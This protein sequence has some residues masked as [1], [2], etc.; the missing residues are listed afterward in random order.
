MVQGKY[1][2]VVAVLGLMLILGAPSVWADAHRQ[3]EL[4]PPMAVSGDEAPRVRIAASAICHDVVDRMPVASGE[5]FAREVSQLFCWTRVMGAEGDTFVIHNWYHKGTLKSTV[6][7]PVRSPNWRTWSAKD[8]D[9]ELTG[10]WMVEILS[11][12]G[13]P[14]E[15]II[16]F[17]K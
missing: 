3:T 4:Y 6:Q 9:P 1:W 10:E 8:M 13:M 7:L 12:D 15:S 11:A 14:L 5:V 2:M 17:V 16:F